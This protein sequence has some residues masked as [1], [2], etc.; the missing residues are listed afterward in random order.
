MSTLQYPKNQYFL[1]SD[2]G[3]TNLGS[4]TSL[5]GWL[6]L[7]QLRILNKNAS[8]YSYQL[9]IVFSASEGGAAIAS[10]EWETFSNSETGQVGACWLGDVCFDV[11]EY[12]LNPDVELY[13]RLET[14]G[15]TLNGT[16]VY[17]GVWCDWIEP[18]GSNNSAAARMT[19]GTLQ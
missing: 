18:I 8:P 10:T 3:S 15:Y 17:L 12:R 19:M 9:R 13:A 6:K 1:I 2:G 5:E 4:F 7:F 16:T 11:E 14:T